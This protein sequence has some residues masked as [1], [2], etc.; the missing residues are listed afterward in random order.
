MSDE[1]A[2]LAKRAKS[3][4]TRTRTSRTWLAA[5]FELAATL[6]QAR[7]QLPNNDAFAIWLREAGLETLTK[8]DRSALINIGADV[9]EAKEV[10]AEYDGLSWRMAW[11]QIRQLRSLR[12]RKRELTVKKAVAIAK[13]PELVRKP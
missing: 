8:D 2:T 4:F 13:L 5:T 7:K 1:L 11:Q 10:F 12:T 9:N 6:R 3:A